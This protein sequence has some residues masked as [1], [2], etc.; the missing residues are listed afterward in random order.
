MKRR[1]SKDNPY[2]I[3]SD[4]ENNIYSITFYDIN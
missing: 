1:K 2:I 3:K 4:N